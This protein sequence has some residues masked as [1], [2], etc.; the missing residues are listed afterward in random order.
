MGLAHAPRACRALPNRWRR[1]AVWRRW[2]PAILRGPH[3]AH[4]VKC[5]RGCET[6]GLKRLA[7]QPSMPCGPGREA[8]MC[9]P[10]GRWSGVSAAIAQ[11]VSIARRT[12]DHRTLAHPLRR[13]A[14]AG[15]VGVGP[16]RLGERR[17]KTAS[18]AAATGSS[19]VVRRNS[20]IP[21]CSRASSLLHD[22]LQGGRV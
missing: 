12:L 1:P 6:G 11:A 15:G 16:P 8:R 20:P 14:W 9:R 10:P 21:S 5:S 19:H 18:S 13:Q 3:L 2:S 22:A 17:V 4:D 7:Y